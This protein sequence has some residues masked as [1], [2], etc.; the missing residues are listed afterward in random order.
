M[1]YFPECFIRHSENGSFTLQIYKFMQTEAVITAD[2][3][4]TLHVPELNEH[5]HSVN[6]AVQESR[7]VFVDAGLKQVSKNEIK[8]LEVGFG[9]GLNAILTLL[10][11]GNLNRSIDYHTI[12]LYPLPWEMIETLNYAEYLH[13]NREQYKAFK[14]MHSVSWDKMHAISTDFNLTKLK[15]S[16][17]NICL[18]SHFD[19]VY[20]DAFGP[21]VQ[22]A[23]WTKRVFQNIY[24]HML[25]EGILVTYSAKGIV[26][27]NLISI[28]YSVERL[29]GPPGKREMLRA[30]KH[31]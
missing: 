16:L 10:E 5:Y 19:L 13:L 4:S 7:H 29:P 31:G 15:Q 18:Q 24:N 9:T 3:S 11:N 30:V 25:P 22:P 17:E 27:R 21:D 1:N 2:G 14:A 26:R 12:E 8:I 6:G 28:G 23:L 20:F